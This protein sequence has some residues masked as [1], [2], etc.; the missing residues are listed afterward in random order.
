[1]AMLVRQMW[2]SELLRFQPER[3]VGSVGMKRSR[4]LPLQR[5]FLPYS[6]KPQ[7]RYTAPS[8]LQFEEITNRSSTI[9][10]VYQY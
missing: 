7:L 3:W 8:A 4:L 6:A 1:M 5:L 10:H 2:P 9:L